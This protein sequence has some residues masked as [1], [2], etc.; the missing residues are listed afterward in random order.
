M[1]TLKIVGISVLS[2]IAIFFI[3][4]LIAPKQYKAERTVLVEAPKEI[5]FKNVKYWNNWK[6]WSPWAEM[7]PT[8]KIT[9][10]GED[11]TV[12]SKYVW[13]GNP[14]LT[15]N[16]EMTAILIKENEEFSYHL[17]FITPWESESMGYTRLNEKDGKIEVAWGFYGEFPYPSNIMLLFLDMQKEMQKDFDRGLEL[18]KTISEKEV[19]LLKAEDNASKELKSEEK[20]E[21]DT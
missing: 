6:K 7:D 18:L 1:K 9:V 21:L 3:L 8:M 20:I 14:E 11:G 2:L 12:G 16:G 10:E 17:H 4:A 15:G 19:E 5:I 13:N